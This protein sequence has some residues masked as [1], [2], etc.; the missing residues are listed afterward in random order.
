MKAK[1]GKL[2]SI[3][4]MKYASYQSIFR[5]TLK[6]VLNDA[7]A[8]GISDYVLVNGAHLSWKG[9]EATEE[10]P[11]LYLGHSNTWKKDLKANK[12]MDLKAYSYGTCKI[13]QVGS[14][15]E[16]ALCP[17]KGKL[18]QDSLLKPLKKIFKSFKPKTFFEVVSNLSAVESSEN[19]TSD[20]A[21][22]DESPEQSLLSTIGKDLQKY[23]LAVEK[24]K[25]TIAAAKT[26]E[27]KMPLLIKQNQILKRL[28][29]LCT[30]WTT[31]IRP[32][33]DVLITD[34]TSETWQKI[35]QKW[36][37]FFE[38]RTAAKEG[39]STD[40]DARKAEEERIYT[41]AL[42]DLDQFYD[43]LEKGDLIDPSVIESNIENLEGLYN[44]WKNFVGKE[45][46]AFDGELELFEEILNNLREEWK[47]EKSKMEAYHKATLKLDK[48]LES[49]ASEKEIEKLLEEVELLA[50]A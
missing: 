34:K 40:K 36:N 46:S 1:L 35:Y 18:T 8:D 43:N 9:A 33:A 20:T 3:E 14:N 47:E 31:D 27:E 16:I 28:K 22:T 32:Q 30:S 7:K 37:A 19:S 25:K 10:Q 26:E 24:I 41:K 38:S 15:I 49:D 6:E 5:K 13:V 48:A 4:K 17:E 21:T 23:H 29:H 50:N 45:A 39:T 11:L 2:A 12:E 42:G 44:K